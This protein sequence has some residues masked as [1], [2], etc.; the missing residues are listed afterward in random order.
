MNHI[1]YMALGEVEFLP[2]SGKIALFSAIFSYFD[3]YVFGGAGV[4]NLANSNA[5][6]NSC[7][8][9]NPPYSVQTPA[10][11]AYKAT[12]FTGN[13]G[14][15]AHAY[16]NNYMAIDLEIRDLIYKN[17]ASGRDVNGDGFANSYDLEWT[18]NYIFG[19]NLQFFA[20]FKAKIN[21]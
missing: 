13:V 15:G 19:L 2:L 5:Q 14:L 21:R 11:Q 8:T 1:G 4:V 16:L 20:P 9:P 10:C 17:N 6:P 18:N 7:V 3:F 12:E